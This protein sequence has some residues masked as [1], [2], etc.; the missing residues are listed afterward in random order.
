MSIKGDGT[1]KGDGERQTGE[2]E[3]GKEEKYRGKMEALTFS[4]VD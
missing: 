3:L 1:D 2:E 4:E